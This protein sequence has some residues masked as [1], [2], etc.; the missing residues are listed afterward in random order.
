MDYHHPGLK[1]S[2]V[3]PTNLH[4]SILLITIKTASSLHTTRQVE[5]VLVP[6]KIKVPTQCPHVSCLVDKSKNI[7]FM[8]AFSN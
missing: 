6:G 2:V 5:I 1:S 4:M 3:S 8:N 7:P